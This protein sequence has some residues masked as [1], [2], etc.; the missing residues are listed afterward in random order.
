MSIFIFS[1]TTEGRELSCRLAT[2]GADVTVCVAT[3]YGTEEQ[4]AHEGVTVLTG[5][6]SA[7][8]MAAL[9]RGFSLCVDAT[10]PYAVEASKNIRAACAA[11]NVPYRRL[12]R[13]K[14][15]TPDAVEVDSAA[16]AAAYLTETEGNVLL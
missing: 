11:A 16:E 12:L 2:R 3:E 6:R 15:E 13:E 5:R 9:L 7:D 10:H 8:E 1:G 14:S 4:G